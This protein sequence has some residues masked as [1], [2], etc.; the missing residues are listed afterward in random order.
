MWSG[1]VLRNGRQIVA[2]WCSER[3]QDAKGFC[4][5][6]VEDMDKEFDD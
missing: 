6:Y 5:Q 1:H 2:G 4:G 3:C